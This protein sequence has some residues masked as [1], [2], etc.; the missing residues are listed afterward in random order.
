MTIAGRRKWSHA[1]PSKEKENDELM[2]D[3]LDENETEVEDQDAPDDYEDY[4]EV[5][6][7]DV[8]DDDE[9]EL[10]ESD[11][12]EVGETEEP[13]P[14]PKRNP[15]L[16]HQVLREPALKEGTYSAIVEDVKA[17]NQ[18]GDYGNYILLSIFFKVK[19]PD[20]ARVT[21]PVRAGM[22]MNPESRLYRIVKGILGRNP[23][24]GTDL[25]QLKGLRVRV[26][27]EHQ[28]DARGNVWEDIVE[29]IPHPQN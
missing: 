18:Q 8:P 1:I 20:K 9:D 21:V 5:N 11:G 4:S 3:N 10:E 23:L 16:M 17:K 19:G 29:I 6:D 26:V 22:S 24:P 12:Y 25:R 14:K 2:D 7:P 28:E 15:F 27:I 13:E